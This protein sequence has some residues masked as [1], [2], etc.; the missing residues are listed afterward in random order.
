MKEFGRRYWADF[1]KVIVSVSEKKFCVRRCPAGWWTG[2]IP[3]REVDRYTYVKHSRIF[4]KITF[5]NEATKVYSVIHSQNVLILFRNSWSKN[6]E[7][8]DAFSGAKIIVYEGFLINYKVWFKCKLFSVEVQGQCD[9]FVF[10]C[11]WMGKTFI[12]LYLPNNTF[13]FFLNYFCIF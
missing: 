3:I 12:I 8:K 5:W 7:L 10:I 11:W 4:N 1:V 9:D 2:R 13:S 6:Y